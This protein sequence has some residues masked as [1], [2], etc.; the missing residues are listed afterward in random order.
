MD[1]TATLYVRSASTATIMVTP[2]MQK[3]MYTSAHQA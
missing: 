1:L 2:R 3:N